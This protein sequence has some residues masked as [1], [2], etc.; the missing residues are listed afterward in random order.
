MYLFILLFVYGFEMVASVMLQV[1]N[2]GAFIS[3]N[4]FKSCKWKKEQKEENKERISWR[5]TEI[6]TARNNKKHW[7]VRRLK[8]R[9]L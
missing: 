7:E 4:P 2:A 1:K 8:Y 5:E 6:E 9:K 3:W